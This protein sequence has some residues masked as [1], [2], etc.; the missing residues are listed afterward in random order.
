MTD[1][2][3]TN[4]RYSDQDLS[5]WAGY[6]DSSTVRVMNQ[7]RSDAGEHDYVEFGADDVTTMATKR[8]QE[9]LSA[10]NLGLHAGPGVLHILAAGAEE[11]AL[12]AG[13]IAAGVVIEVAA[14]C[15]EIVGGD[16]LAS[17]EERDTMHA[18][19]LANLDIP[20]G[21]KDERMGDLMSRYTDGWKAGTQ[22]IA[23]EGLGADKSKMALVQIHADQGLNAARGMLDGNVDRKAYFSAHPE[24]AK[25]YATDPAFKEGFDSLVWAHHEG[26]AEYDAAVSG[27]EARDA[28]YAQ[29]R[30]RFQV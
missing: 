19:M 2:V 21:Y 25:R 12:G 27:L 14:T 17:A 10:K 7:I 3:N 11:S 23:E 15:K 6:E 1:G 22:K 26:R 24:A 8:E 5:K 30:V 9:E 28:R 18:A 16:A 4:N 20:Q 29:A 13:L